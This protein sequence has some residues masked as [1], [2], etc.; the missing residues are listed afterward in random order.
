MKVDFRKSWVVPGVCAALSALMCYALHS[1]L[2]LPEVNRF[3]TPVRVAVKGVQRIATPPLSQ[4]KNGILPLKSV[5]AS[6]SKTPKSRTLSSIKR[7][8]PEMV[9][10]PAVDTAAVSPGT[11]IKTLPYLPLEQP[12]ELAQTGNASQGESTNKESPPLIGSAPPLPGTQ[13]VKGDFPLAAI[14]QPYGDVLVLGLLV[15]DLGNV[16]ETKIVVP[17]KRGLTD[18]GYAMAYQGQKWV[19]LEPPMLPGELRWLELRLDYKKILIDNEI[20]P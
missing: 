12:A 17:S 2:K 3:D 20:L 9:T 4:A 5:T 16:V 15:D 8:S 18:L 10:P 7:P 13:P 14:E 1:L 6:A 11:D 19:N